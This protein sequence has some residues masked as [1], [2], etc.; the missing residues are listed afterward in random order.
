MLDSE[1]DGK[2]WINRSNSWEPLH[3]SVFFDHVGW[4]KALE[5]VGVKGRF[6]SY[7]EVAAGTL[8]SRGVKVL[9]L[10]K[11][12]ALSD[13]EKTAIQTGSMPAAC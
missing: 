1:V 4:S 12:M 2:T 9:I 10:P 11:A 3:C 13:A 5:D 8:T 6:I 7:D